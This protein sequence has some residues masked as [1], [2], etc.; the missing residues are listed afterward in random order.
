MLQKRKRI[1]HGAAALTC[2]LP[3]HHHAAELQRSDGVGHH[4][5]G[6]AR[7]QQDYAGIGKVLHVAAGV[8][9]SDDDEIRRSG[10]AA[11]RVRTAIQARYAIQPA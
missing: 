7:P 10:L 3:R 1:M 2:V 11:S 5:D 8:P 4:Q 9:C 6:P